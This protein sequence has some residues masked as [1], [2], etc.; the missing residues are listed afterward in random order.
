MRR[1]KIIKTIELENKRLTLLKSNPD[2]WGSGDE[3]ALESK[4]VQAINEIMGF[5]IAEDDEWTKHTIKATNEEICEYNI[6]RLQKEMEKEE[7]KVKFADKERG[8]LPFQQGASGDWDE[9]KIDIHLSNKGINILLNNVISVTIP[10]SILTD[11]L[12]VNA[13]NKS[14]RDWKQ[15]L[16]DNKFKEG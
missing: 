4:V 13:L 10:Y 14:G 7:I 15:F 6:M 8:W 3:L 2:Y 9:Y 1:E 5:D 11:D 16:K 12:M